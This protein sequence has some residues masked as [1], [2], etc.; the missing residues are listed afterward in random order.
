[1]LRQKSRGVTVTQLLLPERRAQSLAMLQL[2]QRLL[3]IRRR[4]QRAG[5]LKNAPNTIDFLKQ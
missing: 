4:H 5:E 3:S 2:V 1:M